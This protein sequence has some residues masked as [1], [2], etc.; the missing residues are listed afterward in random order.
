VNYEVRI[1]ADAER[2][3]ESIHDFI[4][5]ND[6]MDRAANAL[7]ALVRAAESP[8]TWPQRGSHP[9]ELEGTGYSQYRQ[10]IHNP[11]RI[12]YRIEGKRVFVAL[13]ADGRRDLRTLLT[14]RLLGA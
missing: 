12:V 2:D 6:G 5:V 11:W 13:V 9:R 4:A 7:D 14:Q 3:L 10:L 8:A 1:G